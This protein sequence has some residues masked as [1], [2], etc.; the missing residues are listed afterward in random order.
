MKSKES[1]KHNQDAQN[2]DNIVTSVYKEQLKQ[3]KNQPDIM[4]L[5]QQRFD[6]L[7]NN[8]EL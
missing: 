2:R 8:K 4:E 3:H 7:K 5:L 6:K 1:L